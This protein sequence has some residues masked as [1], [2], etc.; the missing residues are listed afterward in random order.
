MHASRPPSVL[1]CPLPS[2][3]VL[4]C[5]LPY[6]SVL[7]C[8]VVSCTVFFAP[9]LFCPLLSYLRPVMSS[10]CRVL[11][12]YSS[13]PYCPPLS[14]SGVSKSCPLLFR[15]VLSGPVI[16]YCILRVMLCPLFFYL[17]TFLC[18]ARYLPLKILKIY[19]T[20]LH[21]PFHFFLAIQSLPTYRLLP[22]LYF[23]LTAQTLP[24]LDLFI[25]SHTHFFRNLPRPICPNKP[26]ERRLYLTNFFVLSFN[27]GFQA[28][29]HV[30]LNSFKE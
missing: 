14:F 30:T 3:S 4:L 23:I 13:V 7:L 6:P 5:P 16:S 26:S 18:S 21:P 15:P 17:H 22:T 24:V 2:P 20:H 11:V 9:L 10:V 8:L 29:D 1:F 12:L 25:P 27:P 28:V 19:A